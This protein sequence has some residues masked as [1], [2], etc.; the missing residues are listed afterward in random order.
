MALSRILPSRRHLKGRANLANAL[1]WW[2]TRS[3]LTYDNLQHLASWGLGETGWLDAPQISR[4]KNNRYKNSGFQT[5][6]GLG[7][8]NELIHAW[9]TKGP[10]AVQRT[11]G[12]RPV[13]NVTDMHLSNA[14]WLHHPEFKAE[15]LDFEDFCSVFCGRLALP[16]VDSIAITPEGAREMSHKLADLLDGIMAG[17]EGTTRQ[18]IARLL[19]LY[20]CADQ[21]RHKRLQAVIVG[22]AVFTTE[23]LE[24]ELH[25]CS[26]LIRRARGLPEGS[27]GPDD[28]LAELTSSRRKT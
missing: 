21:A 10:Q 9:Q 4:L 20:E 6:E 11:Y 17:W 26:N 1:D 14:V 12:V 5:F 22:S 23:Q 2:L 27:Y 28:L 8:A 19:S 7:A 16:Y 15:P 24:Q 25:A 13:C 3:G 18:R